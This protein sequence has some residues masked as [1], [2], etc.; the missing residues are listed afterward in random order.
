M[1]FI[2][3]GGTGGGGAKEGAGGHITKVGL[4]EMESLIGDSP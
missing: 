3:I 1:A 4:F 2:V